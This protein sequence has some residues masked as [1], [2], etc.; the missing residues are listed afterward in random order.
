LAVEA[1]S[2]AAPR[3]FEAAVAA[4]VA[5]V[6][7]AARVPRPMVLAAPGVLGLVGFV[8]L[9]AAAAAAVPAR[10]AVPGPGPVAALEVSGA[11]QP[12]E[13]AEPA[14]WAVLQSARPVRSLS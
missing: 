1:V 2:G 9:W 7:V 4:V 14:A 5:V 11:R 12:S 3:L 8:A 6:A 10:A 13:E